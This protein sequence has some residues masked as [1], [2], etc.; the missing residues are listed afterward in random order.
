[1]A[2]IA[3]FP[4]RG[5]ASPSLNSETFS[6]Q[7]NLKKW[8]DNYLWVGEWTMDTTTAVLSSSTWFERKR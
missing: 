8:V 3:P 1:M 5:S 2:N 4:A 6:E 7:P